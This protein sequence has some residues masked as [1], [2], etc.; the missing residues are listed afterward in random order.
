MI[1]SFCNYNSPFYIEDNSDSKNSCI[2]NIENIEVLDII[3][4]GYSSIVFDIKLIDGD[5]DYHKDCVMK[6]NKLV[7]DKNAYSV[8]DLI[9]EIDVLNFLNDFNVA[10]KVYDVILC[11]FYDVECNIDRIKNNTKNMIILQKMILL[12][13]QQIL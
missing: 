10:P 13:I 6:M 8:Q 5:Q 12:T 1:I 9:K 11:G 4:E 7:G 3:G 2:E